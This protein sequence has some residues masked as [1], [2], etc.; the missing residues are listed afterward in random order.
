MYKCICVCTLI[1]SQTYK[2]ASNIRILCSPAI[3]LKV[4]QPAFENS[5]FIWGKLSILFCVPVNKEHSLLEFDSDSS[6]I[7]LCSYPPTLSK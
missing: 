7:Q 2:S 1:E 6:L 3:N 4:S 5:D